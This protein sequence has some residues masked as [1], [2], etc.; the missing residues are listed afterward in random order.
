MHAVVSND[1]LLNVRCTLLSSTEL[2]CED[3]LENTGGFPPQISLFPNNILKIASVLPSTLISQHG[4]LGLQQ[5]PKD[6]MT[7]GLRRLHFS[8]V[9]SL[10]LGV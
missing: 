8:K 9:R 3:K 10:L 5:K 2:L 4:L 7:Q 1:S 6:E